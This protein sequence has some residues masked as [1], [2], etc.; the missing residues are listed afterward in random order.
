MLITYDTVQS[1][2]E[3]EFLKKTIPRSEFENPEKYTKSNEEDIS[4]IERLLDVREG[5][6]ARDSYFLQKY[7][8]PCSRS[9]T[10]YDFAFTALI[11]ANHNKSLILHTLVG[12][13]RIVNKPRITRCSACSRQSSTPLTYS[14]EVN[15][16]G[17]STT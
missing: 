11:D 15:Q 12:A 14:M 1:I 13:K 8:C 17:C 16:Y 10:I 4:K 7:I 9:L 2:T 6:L 5:T 3:E